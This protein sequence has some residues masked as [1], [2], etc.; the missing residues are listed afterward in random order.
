MT[1]TARHTLTLTKQAKRQLRDEVI[2][3]NARSVM[4][5]INTKSLAVMGWKLSEPQ[6]LWTQRTMLGHL[7]AAYEYSMTLVLDYQ[8]D[9]KEAPQDQYLAILRNIHSRASSAPNGRWELATV[10]GGDYIKPA[11]GDIPVADDA[12]IGY[13]EINIPDD[14]DDNFD[15]LYGLDAHIAR[16]KGAI[17]AGIDSNWNNRYNCV[18]IGPPGCGKSDICRS[19][20][21]ALGDDAVI[22]YDATA[23]TAAGMQKDLTEREILPRILIVEEIEK[24]DEKSVQPLMG[25]LD[26]RG[27]IRKTTART[28]IQRDTKLFVIAT[29]NNRAAFERMQSGALASRFSN[30]IWFKRPA[31]DMLARILTREV[32]KVN[33]NL[34]W[35]DPT[36]DYADANRIDDPRQITAL[37]LCGRDGWLDGS[38]VE[39]LAAT[40]EPED[41][42]E[43]LDSPL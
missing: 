10:D 11:K 5:S 31:R 23:T 4:Q 27:E 15:H 18:L 43:T 21:R 19:V 35:I 36:L 37:C 2:Q 7:D 32:Q 13:T 29:V 34:A 33:G 39:M 26:L 3:S 17:E 12:L 20:K 40:A 25:M 1:F 42:T 6:R 41:T 8:S 14:W 24:A 9:A 22:E 38:Y 30:K 28:A 16:I